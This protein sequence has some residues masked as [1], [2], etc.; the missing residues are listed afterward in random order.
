VFA[1]LAR[2][3]Q[4][5]ESMTSRPRFL[6]GRIISRSAVMR[7]STDARSAEAR[8]TGVVAAQRLVLGEITRLL[9]A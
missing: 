7:I 5:R 2:C 4:N 8:W 6:A 1:A 3:D 9:I